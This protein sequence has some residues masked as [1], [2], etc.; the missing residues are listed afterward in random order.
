MGAGVLRASAKDR[1]DFALSIARRA[2]VDGASL[3][4][5]RRMLQEP[6]PTAC[7]ATSYGTSRTFIV[8]HARC[9]GEGGA[10]RTREIYIK[11]A[12]FQI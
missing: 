2:G 1:L 12:H 4:S 8:H 9:A 11:K 3:Q 6:R 7:C 10:A 5:V